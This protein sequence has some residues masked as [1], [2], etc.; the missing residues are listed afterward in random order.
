MFV[1]V[2][3]FFTCVLNVYF[4]K[5]VCILYTSTKFELDRFTINGDIY[6]TDKT[7][8]QKPFCLARY[9]YSYITLPFPSPLFF[10]L[11]L[12]QVFFFSII[13]IYSKVFSLLY[14]TYY[15]VELHTR[16]RTH[17]HTHTHQY[18]HTH[19]RIRI[20]THTYQSH[21]LQTRVH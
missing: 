14:A 2:F 20:H 12:S 8:K 10:S 13:L 9:K 6:L 7:E 17:T 18:T 3:L 1:W 11:S 19:I 16:I 21:T 5:D 15:H 4:S